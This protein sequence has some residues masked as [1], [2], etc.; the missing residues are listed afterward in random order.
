MLHRW[1]TDSLYKSWLY[2]Y[3]F[4]VCHC[5]CSWAFKKLKRRAWLPECEHYRW[6]KDGINLKS[7]EEQNEWDMLLQYTIW[8]WQC[9]VIS[10][11]SAVGTET[12]KCALQRSI[13]WLCTSGGLKESPRDGIARGDGN[14]GRRIWWSKCPW[15]ALHLKI[16]WQSRRRINTKPPFRDG[17]GDVDCS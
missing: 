7:S 14:Q 5:F 10:A 13:S 3:H 12:K 11:T 4:S 16:L 15:R 9:V 6:K 2:Q 1:I 8:V 17:L